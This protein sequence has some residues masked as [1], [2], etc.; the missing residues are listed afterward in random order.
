MTGKDN[1]ND[2]ITFWFSDEKFLSALI[3]NGLGAMMNKGSSNATGIMKYLYDERDITDAKLIAKLV[4]EH[5][6]D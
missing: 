1:Y 4:R 3:R 2:L 6:N 5:N